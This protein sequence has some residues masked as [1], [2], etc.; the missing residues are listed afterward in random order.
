M[1]RHAKKKKCFFP[2]FCSSSL[3]LFLIP[4][5]D[6]QFRSF[7]FWSFGFLIGCP[8][9]LPRAFG[10]RVSNFGFIVCPCSSVALEKKPGPALPLQMCVRRR[11]PRLHKSKPGTDLTGLPGGFNTEL[12][13]PFL[14]HFIFHYAAAFPHHKSHFYYFLLQSCG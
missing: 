3:P 11:K 4:A 6:S 13:P 2:L 8:V 1:R 9:T 14:L 12:Y 5:P 10:F 7:V